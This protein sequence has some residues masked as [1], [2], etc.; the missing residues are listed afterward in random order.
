MSIG[1]AV[2]NSLDNYWRRDWDC[3]ALW[4]FVSLRRL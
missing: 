2:L 1:G 4:L 3:D